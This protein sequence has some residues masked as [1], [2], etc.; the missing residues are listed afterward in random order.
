MH[1]RL[2]PDPIDEYC[3][4]RDDHDKEVEGFMREVPIVGMGYSLGVRLQAMSCSDPR[5]S[6]RCLSMGKRGWLIRSSRDGMVYLS[7][8]NWGARLLIPRVESL[9]GA[10]RKMREAGR[11]R[12]RRWEQRKD[13]FGDGGVGRRDN[14]WDD[15]TG[16]R[17]RRRRDGRDK[18]D[19]YDDDG[20]GSGYG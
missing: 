16:R 18:D 15:G 2:P 17:G 12:R 1:P 11:R 3:A 6:R 5:I 14:V 20:A 19:D 4:D 13:R 9:D 7:F 10:A 8:A